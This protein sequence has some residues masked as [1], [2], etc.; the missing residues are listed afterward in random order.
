MRPDR[1]VSSSARP[2]SIV[3]SRVIVVLSVAAAV[4]AP[5]SGWPQNGADSP[6]IPDTLYT[7]PTIVIEAPRITREEFDVFKRSGFVAVLDL[8]DR[9]NRV[10]DLST[11][12]SKMVGVRVR[13]YGGLGGFATVS[14]RGSSSNQVDVFLDGVPLNDAYMGLTDVGD[15]PLDGIERVEVYRGFTPPHLGSS[16]IGGAVNLTVL[17][18]KVWAGASDT[19]RVEAVGS[20]G[21]FGTSRYAFSLWSQLGTFR[22]FGHA[23]RMASNGDFTFVSDRGTP[24]NP[25]DDGEAARVNND[26]DSWHALGSLLMR[27]PVFGDV[28]I[29]HNY[30]EREQGVPGIGSHQ[31]VTARSERKRH[32]TYLR[33][34]PRPVLGERLTV[35]GTAFYSRT[36]EGF[37]NLGDKVSLNQQ[38]TENEFMAY[39]GVLRSRFDMPLVPM[40]AELFLE[41]NSEKFHP[42][43]TRPLPLS[44]PDRRRM[45]HT[46]AVSGDL[47]LRRLDLVLTATERFVSHT[48][49]FYDPPRFPWLPPTPQGKISRD[50]WTSQFG[51]RW[52]AASFLTIKGNW[53]RYLRLPTFVELFGNTGSVTGSADLEPEEGLNRDVGFVLSHEGFWNIDGMFLET[54]YLDNEVEN[55]ILYFPNSQFTSRPQNIGSAR[56]RGLEISFSSQLGDHLRLAGNYTYLRSKD[57][58]PIPYY[59]GNDLP[60]RPRHD[61]SLFSDVLLETWRFSYELHQIGENYLD[62][63]NHKKVA[64][65]KIHNLAVEWRPFANGVSLA[66][67]AR[68]LTDNQVSDVSGFP[69]PGRSFFVTVGYQP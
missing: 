4:L 29:S 31:S 27:L 44:G 25:N 52:I 9:R 40:G 62:P 63:A 35:S 5:H 11:V 38:A 17:D 6:E 59:N 26:F 33:S 22:L 39:G 65:R 67:E 47:F 7:V 34:E 43:A 23:G 41:S 49:E 46:A 50:A 8:G 28:S 14:I 36:N 2:F 30:V 10:D 32:V 13:Q 45:S 21:S 42:N 56:I 51:F 66:A 15:L 1:G 54:V 69:L 20:Y 61:L 68:N 64:K 16:A 53:G 24:A 48:S 55:L 58:G 57:T 3:F 12:L 18:D 37:S 19:P 60:S